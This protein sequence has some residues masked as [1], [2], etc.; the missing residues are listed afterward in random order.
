MTTVRSMSLETGDM[1]RA[2]G[3][4]HTELTMCVSRGVEVAWKRRIKRKVGSV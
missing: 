1:T 3:L 2:E 4:S